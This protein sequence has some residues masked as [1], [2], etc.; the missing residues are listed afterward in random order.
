M[1]MNTSQKPNPY[2]ALHQ[3]TQRPAARATEAARRE[4]HHPLDDERKL[5]EILE[6][7]SQQE[8]DLAVNTLYTPE[9]PAP[10]TEAPPQTVWFESSV[11]DDS[12]TT[13]IPDGAKPPVAYPVASEHKMM[14][15]LH[16]LSQQSEIWEAP[17]PE[18]SSGSASVSEGQS[19][20]RWFG[21]SAQDPPTASA[22]GFT[23]PAADYLMVSEQDVMFALH[24]L[25][26][27]EED[28][29]IAEL[30]RSEEFLDQEDLRANHRYGLEASASVATTSSS[31]RR[32]SG[33]WL[34]CLGLTS[35]TVTGGGV[36]VWLTASVLS[37]PAH[38]PKPE[39]L[40]A[41]PSDHAQ[42]QPSGIT[43]TITPPALDSLSPEFNT[44]AIKP[45]T[46]KLQTPTSSA[47]PLD[48]ASQPA[49]SQ[50]TDSN[51]LATKPE[52][53][54]IPHSALSSLVQ[55]RL[56]TSDDL[57]GFS[58]WDLTLLRNEIYAR[59]GR[60]FLEPE[61]QQY[62]DAQ[63]WYQPRHGPGS[64]PISNL[65]KIEIQNAIF[66]R[67]YQHAHE[68]FFQWE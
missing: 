40:A 4:I 27:P 33:N 26:E 39:D 68:K 18:S 9:A 51:L 61:L 48:S 15:I 43:A 8:E 19:Q 59:H 36:G 17:D 14:D 42:K 30:Y 62:F 63:S 46:A 50:T 12:L 44:S 65:S 55:E 21:P 41:G 7:L 25:S 13:S 47:P 64:F 16:H 53:T 23:E 66:I 31:P 6:H 22:P 57:Q 10:M 1:P 56:L 2:S 34:T 35:L 32:W 24:H 28:L 37:P 29:E 60:H 49:S 54:A 58:D 52:A 11:Q 38:D 3:K 45:P 20:T 67:D 5:L